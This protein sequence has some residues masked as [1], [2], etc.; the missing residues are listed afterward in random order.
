LPSSEGVKT[1]QKGNQVRKK[2]KEIIEQ[3]MDEEQIDQSF[4]TVDKTKKELDGLITKND[5]T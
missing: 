4:F 1:Y 2:R 5:L 3:V